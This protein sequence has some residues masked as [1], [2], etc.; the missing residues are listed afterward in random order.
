MKTP[1]IYIFLDIDGP[2][3]TGRNDFLAP[4]R[5]GHHFDNDAVGNLRDIIDQ[6]GAKIVISSSWRHMGLSRIQEIWREWNLP[7]EVIGC[8]PGEWGASEA[9]DT[10]GQEIRQWLDDNAIEPFNF[11]VIDDFTKEEAAIGQ[12]E[13]WITVNPHCGISKENADRAIR[14]LNQHC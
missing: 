5:Y 2:L 3:N 9:F 6:T 14:L 8:T 1:Q 4:E 11:V 10:R 12:E 13:F 7:G